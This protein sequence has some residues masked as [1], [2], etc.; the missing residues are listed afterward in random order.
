MGSFLHVS[1][2][3][4]VSILTSIF[5]GFRVLAWR[6]HQEAGSEQCVSGRASDTRQAST[7]DSSILKVT[8]TDMCA[9]VEKTLP[10]SGASG[11]MLTSHLQQCQT[12]LR[13]R[14]VSGRTRMG[15]ALVTSCKIFVPD[16]VFTCGE[17]EEDFLGSLGFQHQPPPTHGEHP[18][19]EAGRAGEPLTLGKGITNAANV[20]KPSVRSTNSQST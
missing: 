16:T 13:E 9:L 20:A 7:G 18:R 1:F 8:S 4:R 11:K 10:S 17:V 19:R 6:R 14:N 15:P 12:Q 5:Y 3:T 2:P